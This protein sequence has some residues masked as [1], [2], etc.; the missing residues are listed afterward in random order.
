MFGQKQRAFDK[1][2]IRFLTYVLFALILVFYILA[3]T[4]CIS[5][6][7]GVPDLFLMKLETNSSDTTEV[8]IGYYADQL[9]EKLLGH[10]ATDPSVQVDV[11][12]LLS[13][14]K[15]I[16]TKIF[17]PS[18]LA[19][20]Q[21]QLPVINMMTRQGTLEGG[22]FAI[23]FERKYS[24]NELYGLENFVP[25][26]V[27]L[28]STKPH[29]CVTFESTPIFQFRPS[30]PTSKTEGYNPITEGISM[31]ELQETQKEVV[32]LELQDH[33]HSFSSTSMKQ[34]TN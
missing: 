16:Q 9:I 24:S 1:V 15:I 33:I 8:R 10:N 2:D 31:S 6:S 14:A 23:T 26:I 28:S 3:L 19:F 22:C 4:G 18:W 25:D 12:T 27:A 5:T 32:R 21:C 34:D 11:Y 17:I 13:T 7:P 30:T 20:N 29:H